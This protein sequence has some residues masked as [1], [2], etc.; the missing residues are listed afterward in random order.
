[1]TSTLLFL[2]LGEG[3]KEQVRQELRSVAPDLQVA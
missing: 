2:S 1:M 3:L